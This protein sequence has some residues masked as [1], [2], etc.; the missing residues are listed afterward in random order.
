MCLESIFYK[1]QK[2][3]RFKEVFFDRLIPDDN[4]LLLYFN[5]F[6]N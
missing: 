3:L 2:V 6:Y 5:G 1:N 4:V